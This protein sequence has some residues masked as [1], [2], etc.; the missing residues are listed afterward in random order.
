MARSDALFVLLRGHSD[1]HL[2]II[3]LDRVCPSLGGLRRRC[4][5]CCCCIGC[6]VPVCSAMPVIFVFSHPTGSGAA[7]CSGIGE[8]WQGPCTLLP[9]PARRTCGQR[10]HPQRPTPSLNR[11]PQKNQR[12]GRHYYRGRS[13]AVRIVKTT[14]VSLYQCR[15]HQHAACVGNLSSSGHRHITSV[16]M[17]MPLENEPASR[18]P[19]WRDSFYYFYLT[20]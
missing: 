4:C 20:A 14:T 19:G 11:C 18:R 6:H 2:S 3:T 5:C 8:Q 9:S 10:R 15:L 16:R 7:A 12:L 1:E 17:M 13:P